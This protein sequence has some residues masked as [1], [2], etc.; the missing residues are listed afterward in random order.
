MG[1]A[2]VPFAVVTGRSSGIGYELARQCLKNGFDV[3]IVADEPEIVDAGA[4]LT[5]ETGRTVET[6]EAD[7][8]TA[9]GIDQL[10][11]A[12]KG[13]PVAALLANA[14]RCQRHA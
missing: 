14:G 10:E 7:L 13:R 3:L 12:I 1:Q 4:Q 8:A 9:E 6:L 5:N 2:V 11:A